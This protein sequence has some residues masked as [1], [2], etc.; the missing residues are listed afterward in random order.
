MSG[1]HLLY[2]LGEPGVGKSTTMATLTAGLDRFCTPKPLHH[3]RLALGAGPTV[4]VE[5]GHSRPGFPG[6]DTLAMSANPLAIGFMQWRTYPLVLAEGDRLANMKF[7]RAA[8]AAGYGVH[9]AHLTTGDPAVPAARRAARGT[10]QNAVWL[11][12]RQTKV[13]NLAGWAAEVG[14]DLLTIDTGARTPAQVV[15]TLRGAWPF[16]DVLPPER[17]P[18]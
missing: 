1:L 5:L 14:L 16:L 18:A 10:V 11:R 3:E 9:I 4:A 12:G 15:A 8:Q 6:T 7:F 13:R 17:V 2:L